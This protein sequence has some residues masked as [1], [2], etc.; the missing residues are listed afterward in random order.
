MKE[1]TNQVSQRLANIGDIVQSQ[2]KTLATAWAD[3]S[4]RLVIAPGE[5]VIAALFKHFGSQYN[6]TTDAVRIAEE[7]R[8]D[9]IAPELQEVITKVLTLVTSSDDFL[10]K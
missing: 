9:E 2:R 4:Q 5:E 10:M 3:R 8:K 6:K 1:I 7:M